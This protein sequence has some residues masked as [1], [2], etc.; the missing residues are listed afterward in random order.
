M[1]KEVLAIFVAIG[2][3][4]TI[5]AQ[6]SKSGITLGYTSTILR[7]SLSGLTESESVSGFH[8]GFFTEFT[9]NEKTK[10]VPELNYVRAIQNGASSNTLYLPLMVRYYAATKLFFQAGPTLDYIIDD[11]D[12]LKKLGYGLALGAGY[13]INKNFFISTKYNFGFNNRL[14]FDFG[15]I[16]GGQPIDF[17]SFKIKY[18]YW[19]LGLGYRF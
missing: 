14:E 19:Y 8:I 10:F 5:N 3:V 7:A 16:N 1:K 6:E 2:I 9:I 11:A 12:G 13:N 15:D 18:N 17:G 4:F